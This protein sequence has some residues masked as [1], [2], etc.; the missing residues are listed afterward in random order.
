MRVLILATDIYT[1]GGIA[2][3]T[4]TLASVL[5]GIIGPNNVHVVALLNSGDSGEQPDKFRI[6]QALSQRPAFKAKVHYSLQCFLAARRK[7]DLII[8]SHCALSPIAAAIER[9]F[10]TPFWVAC[11]DAE[12]W[13]PVS[14]PIRM[15]LNRAQFVLPVSRFTAERMREANGIPQGKIRLLCN[16]IPDAFSNML[17]GESAGS[18]SSARHPATHRTLLSVGSLARVHDY[19]GFDNVIRTLPH[20]LAEVHDLQYTIVGTGDNQMRLE[21][22]ALQLGVRNRVIF[23][24]RVNDSRLADLYRSCEV[25]VMPSR[26]PFANGRW[27]GEGFG[28]VYAEAALAGRPVVGSLAGGAAEAVLHQKTGLLIDPDSIS[29]LTDALAALLRNPKSAGKMG[30]EGRAWARKSFSEFS[31]R[32]S[33]VGVLQ[34]GGHAV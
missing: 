26:S 25:F 33:L 19:K 8:C 15:A 4:S 23:A 31:L 16:A 17:L 27:R 1:R 2:R 13:N 21:T 22:L 28:R 34:A 12:V 24:G 20:L 3:Y 32:S 30:C 10:R 29:D 6:L 7:Y 9:A 18:L 11:H 14:F 5:G